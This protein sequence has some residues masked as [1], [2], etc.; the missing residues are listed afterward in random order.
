MEYF[1]IIFGFNETDYI[2]ITKNELPKAIW[3]FKEGSS[4]SVFEE[5]AIRGQDIMRIVPDW[6]RA[7][8]WNKGWKMTAD[9]FADISH[10]EYSYKKIYELA[11]N[12]ADFAINEKNT[13][14]LNLPLNEALKIVPPENKQVS[15]GAKLLANNMKM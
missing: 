5:G 6:H 10:L 9:D 8:G 7:K 3:L 11:N 15:S 2:S 1:K 4:R 12:I 13:N 14:I